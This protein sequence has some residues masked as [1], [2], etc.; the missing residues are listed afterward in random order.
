MKTSHVRR[1][2]IEGRGAYESKLL[3]IHCIAHKAEAIA[4][5]CWRDLTKCPKTEK[6]VNSRSHAG[7][8]EGCAKALSQGRLLGALKGVMM[9]IEEG[10][11]LVRDIRGD[12]PLFRSLQEARAAIAEATPEGDK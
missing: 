1:K 8:G 6:G 9:L 2:P 11:L 3:P 4:Q 12:V 7:T 5:D 10:K